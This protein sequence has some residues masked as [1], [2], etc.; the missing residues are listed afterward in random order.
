M[1]MLEPL[2]SSF[3]FWMMPYLSAISE[4]FKP[5]DRHWKV[6]MFQYTFKFPFEDTRKLLEIYLTGKKLFHIGQIGKNNK[7]QKY[8]YKSKNHHVYIF[9][10]IPHTVSC[11]SDQSLPL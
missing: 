11:L 8:M 9:N 6:G 10:C 1:V 2:K 7:E 5:K 4:K 3:G